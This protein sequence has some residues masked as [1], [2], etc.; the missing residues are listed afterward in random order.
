MRQFTRTTSF[1]L[2]AVTCLL[3]SLMGVGGALAHGPEAQATTAPKAGAKAEVVVSKSDFK[4]SVSEYTMPNVVLIDADERPVKLREL[5]ATNDPV[6]VNFIFTSCST[7]CPVMARVFAEMP[8]V[9]GVDGKRLR[10]V[11]ISIDP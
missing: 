9:L 7:I 8:S 1:E 5:M 10:M 3:A 6:M 4:R 11:S 2:R